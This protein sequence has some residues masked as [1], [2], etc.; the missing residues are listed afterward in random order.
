[1]EAQLIQN[2]SAWVIS[3]GMPVAMVIAIGYYFWKENQ[4]LN[5]KVDSLQEKIVHYFE[6]DRNK[7]IEI[8]EENTG[9]LK[10]VGEM[11]SFIKNRI[12]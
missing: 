8:L 7:L 1:M 2:L 4:K 12:S 6:N 3:Q 10:Q 5:T 11:V 9:A